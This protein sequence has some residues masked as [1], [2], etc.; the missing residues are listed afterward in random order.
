[1]TKTHTEII[2]KITSTC[3][4]GVKCPHCN[5]SHVTKS[6]KNIHGEQRYRCCNPECKTITFMLEY[7]YQACAPGVKDKIV[8]M[9]VNASGI[10]DTARVLGINKNTVISTLKKNRAALYR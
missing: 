8:E 10:R 6:G 4:V 2:S 9:A 5:R 1:M 3:S 7:R